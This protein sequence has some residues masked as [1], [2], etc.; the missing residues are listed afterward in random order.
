MENTLVHDAQ[1]KLLKWGYLPV[2]DTLTTEEAC[3]LYQANHAAVLHDDCVKIHGRGL[4]V[5]GDIG[6]ATAAVMNTRFCNCPD[7]MPGAVVA[8][9][10]WPKPCRDNITI[11]WNF[12]AAPGLT[13]EET[14]AVWG[15]VKEEYERLFEMGVILAKGDYPQTRIYAALK[16]LPGSTLAWSYLAQNN[17]SARLQQ[18]YY[19]TIRWSFNL[20]TGTWKHE[21]GHAFGM[22]HTP[23]DRNSLMYPS[24]NGQTELNGT[25]IAQMI[26]LG[27]AR[28][29]TPQDPGWG[30]F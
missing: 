19:S 10:N 21:C 22:N 1:G 29:T 17:C 25:D 6:P 28:R 7:I 13:A 5:D 24:M 12:D 11:G 14:S 30:M 3:A 27:Y 26:R 9:A 18:A 8:E 2:D 20:A 16:A 23:G 4:H 15:S